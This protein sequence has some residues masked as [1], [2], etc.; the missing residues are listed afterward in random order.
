MAISE[1]QRYLKAPGKIHKHMFQ[2]I[3]KK[4]L[5]VI[6]EYFNGRI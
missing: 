5:Q 1:G 4:Q 6:K 3:L 2:E